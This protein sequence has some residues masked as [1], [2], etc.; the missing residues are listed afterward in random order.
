MSGTTAAIPTI[1][2]STICMPAHSHSTAPCFDGNAL[3]LCLYFD[4]VE[5]L[6]TDAGLNDKGKT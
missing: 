2:V 6:S 3:N 4:E 1:H 5:A